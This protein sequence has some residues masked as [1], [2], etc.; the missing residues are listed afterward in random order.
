MYLAVSKKNL[1]FSLL[2]IMIVCFCIFVIGRFVWLHL[3]RDILCSIYV[4]FARCLI[5]YLL[6]DMKVFFSFFDTINCP[7]ILE[8]IRI[9]FLTLWISSQKVENIQWNQ[10][11]L[12]YNSRW[13]WYLYPAT[14]ELDEIWVTTK[15]P[16]DSTMIGEY[17]IR[18]CTI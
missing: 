7:F 8:N 17:L 18:T 6:N 15:R 3:A 5:R 14:R 9:Y 13:R 1:F 2:L 12:Y 10:D 11:R 4:L 16:N